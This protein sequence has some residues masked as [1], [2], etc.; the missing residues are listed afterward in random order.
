MKKNYFVLIMLILST[1]LATSCSDD[2]N[3]EKDESLRISK[4]YRGDN[5][6]ITLNDTIPYNKG[7]VL[8]V[9]DEQGNATISLYYVMPLE[10]TIIFKDVK[11]EN[12]GNKNSNYTFLAYSENENLSLEVA[13]EVIDSKLKINLNPTIT[14]HFIGKWDLP[15]LSTP[16]NIMLD[17]IPIA[18]DATIDMHGI[19]TYGVTPLVSDESSDLNTFFGTLGLFAGMIKPSLDFKDNGC[20]TIAWNPLM[21]ILPAGSYSGNMLYYNVDQ[22]NLYLSLALDA[23]IAEMFPGIT[24]DGLSS[25][26]GISISE[27]EIKELYA[28]AQK[29]YTG[30]PIQYTITT[31]KNGRTEILELR[32]PKE[33][34]LPIL[35]L[36]VPL[37]TPTLE[38]LDWKSINDEAKGMGG[39]ELNLS[40]EAVVGVLSELVRVMDESPKFDL[41]LNLNR[42]VVK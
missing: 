14:N 19:M 30:L 8:L 28:L 36:A 17:I 6:E 12:F 27:Q 25:I 16:Q 9:A 21:P 39:L 2:E 40:S 18:P 31:S 13:G 3:W 34:L 4:V 10:D 26:S 23:I 1:I 38:K 11:L 7:R 29:A 42:K 37:L 35:K 41:V 15:M 24:L 5:L 33:Y 20:V 22:E 32:I